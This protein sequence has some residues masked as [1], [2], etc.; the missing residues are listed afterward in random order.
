MWARIA[1]PYESGACPM[2]IDE[3]MLNKIILNEEG[4]DNGENE[5]N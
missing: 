1:R 4:E 2:M 5:K 3:I